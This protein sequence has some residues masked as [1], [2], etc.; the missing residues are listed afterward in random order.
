MSVPFLPLTI[1]HRLS[2]SCPQQSE[3]STWSP[4]F[5]WCCDQGSDRSA[6]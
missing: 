5:S 1:P 6:H 4:S 3:D 2:P